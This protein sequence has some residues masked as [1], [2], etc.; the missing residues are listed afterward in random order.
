MT[1][2][3][4]ASGEQSQGIGQVTTAVTQIDQVTQTNASSAEECA[5]AAEE[6]NAQAATLNEAVADLQRLVGGERSAS[7]ANTTAP[8]GTPRAAKAAA[9]GGFLDS[10]PAKPVKGKSTRVPA[11]ADMHFA[12]QG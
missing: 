10:L 11:A 6:L 9:K 2:I 7:A 5:A 4:S 8:G 12:D 3:A 1:E